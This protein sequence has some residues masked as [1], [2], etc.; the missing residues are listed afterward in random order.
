V[1]NS[2]RPDQTTQERGSFSDIDRTSHAYYSPTSFLRYCKDT[3]ASVVS[4]QTVLNVKLPRRNTQLESE[5]LNIVHD[6]YDQ[7]LPTITPLSLCAPTE[8]AGI[9]THVPETCAPRLEPDDHWEGLG[10]TVRE[11]INRSHA[12]RLSSHADEADHDNG[13]RE[14]STTTSGLLKA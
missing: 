1:E 5:L 8:G 13:Q 4:L 11:L 7:D 12:D 3:S 9:K 10:Y 2:G 6:H 14:T